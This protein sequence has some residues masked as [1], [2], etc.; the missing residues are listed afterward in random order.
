MLS[1]TFW[2]EHD[3]YIEADSVQA[4]ISQA[5]QGTTLMDAYSCNIQVTETL[6][7]QKGTKVMSA[8]D[9]VVAQSKDPLIREIKYLINNNELKRCKVDSQD[10]QVTK[11][12]LRQHSHLVLHKGVLYR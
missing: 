2:G 9:R 10:P 6:D 8:E 12:Y 7:V 3:Q 4:L 5:M 1:P 11:Q